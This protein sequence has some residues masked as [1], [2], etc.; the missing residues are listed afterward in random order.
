MFYKDDSSS[1]VSTPDRPMISMRGNLNK[2]VVNHIHT[3]KI[4][5]HIKIQ[6]L[7]MIKVTNNRFNKY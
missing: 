3:L 1:D 5:R 4:K 7:L 6:S 2:V